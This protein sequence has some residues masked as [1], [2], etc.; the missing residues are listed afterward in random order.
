M[1]FTVTDTTIHCALDKNPHLKDKQ[2]KVPNSW[3]NDNWMPIRDSMCE[4]F[5]PLKEQRS[6]AWIDEDDTD[7]DIAEETVGLSPT[8]RRAIAR[9]SLG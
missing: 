3:Q 7:A 8:A 5:R 6:P 2:V 9:H 1:V 4:R